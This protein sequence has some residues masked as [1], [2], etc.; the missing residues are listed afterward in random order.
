MTIF[1]SAESVAAPLYYIINFV[2]LDMVFLYRQ[3]FTTVEVMADS[4]THD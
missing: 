2:A 1:Y 4:L 3:R